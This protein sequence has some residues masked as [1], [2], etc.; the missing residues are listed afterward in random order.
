MFG[1]QEPFLCTGLPPEDALG[2]ASLDAAGCR[3]QLRASE[4]LARAVR[5]QVGAL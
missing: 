1:W 4:T 2:L 5:L 3:A